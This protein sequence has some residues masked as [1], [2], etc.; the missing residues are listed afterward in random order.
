MKETNY[1]ST[2]SDLQFAGIETVLAIKSYLD[3][4]VVAVAVST[5]QVKTFHFK[6]TDVQKENAAVA[7]GDAAGT[8][9]CQPVKKLSQFN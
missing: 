3:D 2:T 7:A 6:F 9:D 5:F 8:R 4:D 1:S